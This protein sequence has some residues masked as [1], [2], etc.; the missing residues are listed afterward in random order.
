[1]SLLHNQLPQRVVIELRQSALLRLEDLSDLLWSGI[2]WRLGLNGNF[3]M[4]GAICA[5]N[6]LA[7]PPAAAAG[8]LA[9]RAFADLIGASSRAKLTESIWPWLSGVNVPRKFRLPDRPSLRPE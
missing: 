2:D 3:A 4:T 5:Q 1:M 7:P 8:A 6:A 9:A